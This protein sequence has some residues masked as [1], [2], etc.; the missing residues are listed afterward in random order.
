MNKMRNPYNHSIYW[1]KTPYFNL[2]S[3]KKAGA[4]AP[5]PALFRALSITNFLSVL[6]RVQSLRTKP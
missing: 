6:A 3:Y 2:N 4:C 1:V 5:A